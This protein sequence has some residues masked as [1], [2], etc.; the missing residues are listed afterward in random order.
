MVFV[1]YVETVVLVLLH[2]FQQFIALP[3][4]KV[5][6]YFTGLLNST[7]EY[8][9]HHSVSFFYSNHIIFR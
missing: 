7:K 5:E 9:R 6:E 2:F 1:Y 3:D 8:W 4:V